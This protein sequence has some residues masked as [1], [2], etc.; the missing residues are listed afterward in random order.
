MIGVEPKEIAEDIEDIV[1]LAEQGSTAIALAVFRDNAMIK[2]YDATL[3]EPMTMPRP[4]PEI[5]HHA[6]A[7]TGKQRVAFS[8]LSTSA[9]FTIRLTDGSV[10]PK[11]NI[12]ASGIEELYFNETLGYLMIGTEDHTLIPWDVVADRPLLQQIIA[13]DNEPSIVRADSTGRMFVLDEEKGEIDPL[14]P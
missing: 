12:A 10:S 13:T 7:L 11:I 2:L 4:L 14:L 1:P 3:A 8:T 5:P 6:T 9:Y